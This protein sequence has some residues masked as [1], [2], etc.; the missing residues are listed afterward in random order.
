MKLKGTAVVVSPGGALHTMG[1]VLAVATML[2]SVVERV[3]VFTPDTDRLW[4]PSSR[5][6]VELRRGGDPVRAYT[7]IDPEVRWIWPAKPLR[8]NFRAAERLLE[9]HP[10]AH[11]VVDVDDDDAGLTREFLAGRR[12]GRLRLFRTKRHRQLLPG[13]IAEYRSRALEEAAAFS[14][15][16]HTL[17]RHYGLPSARTF[18]MIHPRPIAPEP[19]ARKTDPNG[20]VDLGFFG[21][22][23][24]HKGIRSIAALIGSDPD[25]RLHLFAGY[26]P[27][28]LESIKEQIVE[29]PRDG[30]RAQESGSV[31]AILL[32]QQ[33]SPAAEVQVPTKLIDAM[34]FGVPA[35]VTPT[36][37]IREVGGDTV[38]Y[39]DNWDDP[40]ASG[41]AVRRLLAEDGSSGER[42]RKLF[43]SELSIEAMAPGLSEFLGALD[44]Q[45]E[46]PSRRLAASASASR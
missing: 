39:L 25:F 9:A 43:E 34:R 19:R 8:N 45:R 26:D 15:S 46:E 12:L 5:W 33:R 31:D 28:G 36:E 32:P 24:P 17:A 7:D 13:A 21:T 3:S 2:A 30:S 14:T 40:I 41:R 23:R 27:T 6:D 22:V 1:R 42:A 16:S 37:A 29:H 20:V 44:G 11:L 10:D 4:P 18:R 35:F 38:H